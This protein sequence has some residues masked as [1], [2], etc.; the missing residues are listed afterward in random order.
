M[1]N[2]LENF[3]KKYLLIFTCTS[4]V[5]SFDQLVGV[6]VE[7]QPDSVNS[8]SGQ[9]IDDPE[10]SGDGQFLTSDDL[11]LSFIQYQNISKCS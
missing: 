2:Y 4:L 6:L 1:H 11:N 7:F 8:L 9:I 3:F 5:L 10:T